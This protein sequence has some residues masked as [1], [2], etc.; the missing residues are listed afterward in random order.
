MIIYS[1]RP[2]KIILMYFRC[3]PCKKFTP[4]L[5][6]FY[7]KHCVKNEI[8]IVYISSDRD[9][10]SFDEYFGKMPWLSLPSESSVEVKQNLADQL[11]ISGLPTLV[12]LD[13]K[14]NFVADRA[15]EEVSLAAGSEE[16]EK[17]L[18][19]KWK[20]TET[21]PICEAPLSGSGP[22]GMIA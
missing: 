8:E 12:V 7:Q 19:N 1:L 10:P 4:V 22:P 15:R 11:K 9:I 17:S 5:S 13:G 3:P 20:S 6:E 2:S 18:V 21:M 14:G 16:K